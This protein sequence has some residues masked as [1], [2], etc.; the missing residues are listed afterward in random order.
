MPKKRPS[1][2][3]AILLLAIPII[4]TQLGG[5]LQGWADTIMVG[6]YGTPELS[7]AGFVNNVF[8]LFIFFLL[9][10]SYATT[11]IVGALY[12]QGKYNRVARTLHESNV[13]NLLASIVVVCILF[14]LYLNI[15]ALG[16]PQELL[17][18]IRP[19][20]IVLLLS[21]P[22]MALFNSM[23]QFSDALGNTQI[24]MWVMIGSNIVN[25]L[26]NYVLIFT[27][28]WGLLGAGLST[29]ISRALMPLA[30]ALAM[31][32][33]NPRTIDCSLSSFAGK[34]SAIS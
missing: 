27:F 8:N 15:D 22:F 25:I 7:A 26:L 34:P 4:I 9:G 5:I 17:P 13:V 12:T 20:F 31:K 23:K 2:E 30:M 32:K 10:I 24:A 29:L 33:W 6:Q 18:L 16:Q 21:L 11:P 19:Y 14:V 28:N 3:M 1:R